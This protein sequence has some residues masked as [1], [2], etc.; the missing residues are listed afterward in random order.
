[1]PKALVTGGSGFLGEILVVA[2]EAR[3]WEVFNLDQNPT[4]YLMPS[5][6]FIG[7]IRDLELCKSATNGMDVVFHN[8]AQVP[9]SK[10]D[11]LVFSVNVQGT[12]NILRAA[13]NS[14]VSN[15]V[16]TSSSAIFGL[17]DSLPI[18]GDSLPKPIEKYGEA[19]LLGEELCMTYF[20]SSMN[21]K[22]VR[23]RTILSASRLGLFGLLYEWINSGVDVLLLGK[24][25]VPYQFIHAEDLVE[26]L[27]RTLAT[28]GDQVFNLGALEYGS[29]RA[30]LVQLCLF[31]GS[32]S[33]IVTIPEFPYRG[34]I[35]VISKMRLLPFAP[36]QV[37]LYGK[38]MYFNSTHDWEK[39]AYAPKHSN[40]DCL[41]SGY[42]W[43]IANKNN[44][45]KNV[46]PHKSSLNG[47]SLRTITNLLKI[48]KRL[49]R[50]Y[51]H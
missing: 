3:G 32:G 12:E 18:L 43:Y 49:K 7:D 46:S 36:Y 13:M 4:K 6:Q 33:E 44:L 38:G 23:P 27:I 21:I 51:K 48:L 25:E 45:S 35:R 20:N 5:K 41:I 15:F 1:M 16:Y 37:E 24:G 29:F 50:I 11:S 30:D 9:L 19:K 22:I 26:G 14:N 42:E 31:A 2:L 34:L 47:L 10:D 40:S 8:V 28:K 39:L 17:P